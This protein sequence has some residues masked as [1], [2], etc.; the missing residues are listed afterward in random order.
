MVERALLKAIP[1]VVLLLASCGLE[2]EI[3][4]PV[5]DKG[6]VQLPQPN[7]TVLHG[8]A[9]ALAGGEA[10]A[11]TASG[12]YVGG[13]AIDES[14]EFVIRFSGTAEHH[15]LIL[16]AG[17]DDQVLLGV[18][19]E[20]PRQ[21]TVFHEERHVFAWEQHSSLNDINA[22]STAIALIALRASQQAGVG[23]DAL[24]SGAIEEGLDQALQ[25]LGDDE[26]AVKDFYSLVS[27]LASEAGQST[28]GHPVYV[29]SGLA[30]DTAL[31]SSDWL[32]H[33]SLQG[34]L[35]GL[36]AASFDQ[37]WSAAAEQVEIGMDNQ[38]WLLHEQLV[39]APGWVQS[40]CSHTVVV[41]DL[42]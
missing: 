7:D 32:A 37:L 21:P 25:L 35:E 36:S 31:L 15:G 22:T 13:A 3:F 33:V 40:I 27:L 14:G 16:W 28:V 10:V 39:V 41:Q 20:L 24:S 34:G 9:T 8:K 5:M 26:P 17:K 6:H 4:G 30:G 2:S 18:L 42:G 12:Q 19:P 11:Y 38:G 1:V 29:S 23:L